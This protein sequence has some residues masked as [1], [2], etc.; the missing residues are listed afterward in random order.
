MGTVKTSKLFRINV[1]DFRNITSSNWK[2]ISFDII[3]VLSPVSLFRLPFQKSFS[4][5][6]FCGY[7]KIHWFKELVVHYFLSNYLLWQSAKL[8]MSRWWISIFWTVEIY[9]TTN[10]IIL[11]LFNIYILKNRCNFHQPRAHRSNIDMF[12][13]TNTMISFSSAYLFLIAAQRSLW[14]KNST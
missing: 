2:L 11:L 12:L 10:S 14:F 4:Y 6:K 7:E 1:L 3:F 5:F 13:N 8:Y 9:C